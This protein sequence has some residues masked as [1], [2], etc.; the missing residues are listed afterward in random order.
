MTPETQAEEPEHEE[1]VHD[2]FRCKIHGAFHVVGLHPATPCWN[3]PICWELADKDPALNDL[4]ARI[5]DL[6][7]RNAVLAA[8]LRR[9][10]TLTRETRYMAGD[11]G[12][13]KIIDALLTP[14][15]GKEASAPTDV[16]GHCGILRRDHSP[17]RHAFV[18][19]AID[20]KEA[21]DG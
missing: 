14:D 2:W 4:H 9:I 7:G 20:A 8:G 10:D 18:Q 19:E 3:C 16:C 11:A 6:E 17:S 12:V 15:A 13:T 5:R 1:P 21:S